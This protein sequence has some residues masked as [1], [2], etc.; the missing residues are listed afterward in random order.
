MT[1]SVKGRDFVLSVSTDGGSTFNPVGG[2][3]TR[4]F[5]RENPIENVT[6]QAT[7]GN[8]TESCF[9]GYGTVTISGELTSDL[10]EASLYPLKDLIAAANSATPV[11]LFKL[12][13]TD[14]GIWEGNFLL[15]SQGLSAEQEGIVSA[16]VALQNE[17]VITF[18]PGV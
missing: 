10:R 11:L 16:S 1:N 18:T 17:G 6:N 14:L 7:T 12:E 8:E 5:T 9:T 13:N 3:R 2:L 4:E 15:T